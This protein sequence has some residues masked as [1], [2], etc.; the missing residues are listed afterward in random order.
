MDPPSD[1]SQPGG[2][3]PDTD[4]VTSEDST[5]GAQA[6][7]TLMVSTNKDPGNN[8]PLQ[9]IQKPIQNTVTTMLLQGNI[10]DPN[11]TASTDPT[12]GDEEKKK[13]PARKRKDS[14]RPPLD[15]TRI[16]RKA[17]AIASNQGN[18]NVD[19]DSPAVT[20]KPAT[21]TSAAK[22]KPGK[23]NI[24]AN[25][26]KNAGTD[27]DWLELDK[28]TG[29]RYRGFRDLNGDI[30][31]VQINAISLDG[32]KY[33]GKI[34]HNAA[35]IAL[36]QADA[37]DDPGK[38]KLT[39]TMQR[40]IAG[41]PA[42]TSRPDT[43][44]QGRIHQGVF[45][46]PQ[47]KPAPTLSAPTPRDWDGFVIPRV[48]PTPLTVTPPASNP[49]LLPSLPGGITQ[50][51][52]QQQAQYNAAAATGGADQLNQQ[53]QFTQYN[54]AP[55]APRQPDLRPATNPGPN[56]DNTVGQ[57]NNQGNV[58]MT[59][60]MFDLLINNQQNNQ[61][62]TTLLAQSLQ[63]SQQS[64]QQY[65]SDAN[66]N[67]EAIIERK[68]TEPDEEKEAGK[69]K[70]VNTFDTEV[71]Q[72][73]DDMDSLLTPARYLPMPVCLK[74]SQSMVPAKTK[75]TRTNYSF[76][77]FGLIVNK[78]T[79]ITNCHDRKHPGLQLKN[80]RTDNLARIDNQNKVKLAGQELQVKDSD[81]E[82]TNKYQAL[83]ALLNFHI[84]SSQICPANTETL[85]LLCAIF[86]YVLSG[87]AEPSSGDI[88]EVFVRW[89]LLRSDTVGKEEIVPYKVIADLVKETVQN[90]LNRISTLTNQ[91]AAAT[92]QA[93]A[94]TRETKP[95]YSN[96]GGNRGGGRGRGA[97]RGGRGGNNIKRT[98]NAP[99]PPSKKQKGVMLC[100]DY[101]LPTGCPRAPAAAS[102]HIKRGIL[103]HACSHIQP[104]G[105][106]CGQPHPSAGNH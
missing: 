82:L 85:T 71:E 18:S 50:M 7:E 81:Q 96:R 89:T 73:V 91:A 22:T 66:T 32:T 67:M 105:L 54:P 59:Q 39:V 45:K 56:M 106:Q 10:S 95:S 42:K 28:K 17:A 94:L 77:Q 86:N 57:N 40:E 9:V 88:A 31:R 101:N 29:Y 69:Q 1:N 60:Q 47:P 55:T 15:T 87:Q 2:G 93:A 75:P 64:F 104:T 13:T 79:A 36:N 12:V 48:D 103:I 102:C 80:F 35:I 100:R 4:P 5:P 14:P 52:P 33:R 74:T 98:N 20:V 62:N 65:I 51:N 44:L 34:I 90:R 3:T 46:T 97:N 92:Q 84:I 83:Q 41:K 99:G 24:P 11:P 30:Y 27:S 70:T 23:E 38:N 25:L 72:M 63:L 21:K 8:N 37:L 58:T 76:H 49:L 68:N 6:G 26:Q 19:P 16:T 43:P 78:F 53:E 61:A